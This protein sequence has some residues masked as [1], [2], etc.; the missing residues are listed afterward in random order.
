MIAW[1]R[2]GKIPITVWVG[3]GKD[4][5]RFEFASNLFAFRRLYDAIS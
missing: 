1:L 2:F 5:N 3:V 4:S